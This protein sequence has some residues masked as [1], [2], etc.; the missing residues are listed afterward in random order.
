MRD[1]FVLRALF[2]PAGIRLH[3]PVFGTEDSRLRDSSRFSRE[4][5]WAPGHFAVAAPGNPGT[6]SDRLKNLI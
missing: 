3:L 2:Y 4:F 6:S 5:T 1:P